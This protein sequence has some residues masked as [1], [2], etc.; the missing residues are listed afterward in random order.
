MWELF[1]LSECISRR[2]LEDFL[3]D[4]DSWSDRTSPDCCLN[5]AYRS[6][7]T[8]TIRISE[9]SE[10]D[11]T[12]SG[13]IVVL[14]DVTEIRQQAQRESLSRKLEAVGQL[15]SGIAHEIN[16]PMQYVGDSIQFLAE[17]FGSLEVLVTKYR[18]AIAALTGAP[19]HALVAQAIKDAEQDAELDYI[20]EN[21]P[22]AFV[23]AAEGVSRVTAIVGA[24]KEFAHPD[25][26]EKSLAD[27]NRAL[28]AT[29]TIA[30]NEYKYVAD[31]QTELG[32][33]PPVLCHGGD[34][35]QVLLNLIVNAAH[36]I[37]D[38]IDRG[39]NK[40]L[41]RVR[42]AREGDSVRIDL[43]DTGCGI[44]EAIRERIFDPFF[45]TKEVGRG[46]G[47]GL[48]IARS[49]VID[50]HGGSLKFESEV[51]RGTTFIIL[52]PI[53]GT[54]RIA[55]KLEGLAYPPAVD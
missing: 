32:E 10:S 3:Q 21:T 54:E 19:E 44:P 15:A 18:Q 55:P 9:Y 51:G 42:T 2:S 37:S 14:Q 40:G 5:S 35:N 26:R 29:L 36:A 27:I 45:T 39:S 8:I 7:R 31:I 50:K 46:S 25:S 43:A 6:A 17:S 52:L 49:I 23:R 22:A 12:Q 16:T 48:A 47:Q 20:R 41:I 30:R 33:I 53:N 13:H 4:R 34:I 11:E 38:N 1:P 28:L 24:M